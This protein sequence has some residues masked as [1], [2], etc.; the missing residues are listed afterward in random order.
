MRGTKCDYHGQSLQSFH[1]SDADYCWECN[2]K[3]VKALDAVER[4]RELHKPTIAPFPICHECNRVLIQNKIQTFILY[5]C[6]TIQALQGD[7]DD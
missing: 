4:V 6:P 1:Y 2:E 7:N 3:M 5:P